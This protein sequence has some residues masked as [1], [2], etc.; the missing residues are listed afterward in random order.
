MGGE[1]IQHTGIHFMEYMGEVSIQTR[2]GH[3]R[4]CMDG[5]PSECIGVSSRKC[6]G[7]GN[8]RPRVGSAR[9]I[10]GAF[11]QNRGEY[12]RVIRGTVC[13]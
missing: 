8:T 6:I 4:W 1:R 9:G 10:C 2:G 11:G 7:R 13:R 3:T 5:R 12:G